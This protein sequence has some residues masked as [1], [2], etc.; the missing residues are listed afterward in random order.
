MNKKFR[1]F[2]LLGVALIAVLGVLLCKIEVSM[3]GMEASRMAVVEAVAD[4]GVYHIENTHF[5]TVDKVI[6]N[7]HI[8]SDKPIMLSWC[9]AQMCK[10][11]TLFSGRNFTNSYNF[12]IYLVNIIFGCGANILC[13]LWLFRYLCRTS[14]GDMRLKLLFAL[15]CCCGTW[16]FSFMTIFS[17]HV[18]AAL[19]VTAVMVLLDKYRRKADS[20]AAVLAGFA[21]GMLFT[22]DMVAG[23]VFLLTSA[24][25]VWFTSPV[26]K[27]VR[28][29][30]RCGASG[31]CVVAFGVCL[32][33]AAYGTVFPLYMGSGGTFSPGVDAKNHFVYFCETLFTTRGLFSYQP[34][35]LLIFPAVWFLRRKLQTN[36]K[37]MLIS[38]FSVI[39][40]YCVITNE[41]GGFS[42]G[43]RYL[44]CVIPILVYYVAKYVLERKNIRLTV[45][46]A[47]LGVAGVFCAFVGAYEPM[48][49]AFE[50]H[51][52]P[53]GHFTRNLRST[54]MSNLF[55]W[56]YETAPDSLLTRKFIGYYGKKDSFLYLRAQYVITKH[57]QTLEKLMKDSRFDLKNQSK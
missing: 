2:S 33:Y 30:L 6:R 51:R 18:P 34:L 3:A 5:R 28:D 20:R 1:K 41:F 45:C 17:N 49:V 21:S 8:Y 44:I 54:F 22:L 48:C 47:V 39:A 53:Q 29:F 55:A 35:L 7:N 52:S 23:A 15:F 40:I 13:F 19:A 56:S 32:N 27:R 37:L 38:G 43:F 36:D 16:M 14:K 25:S 50:G 11:V 24:L 46:A 57:F 4:Q 9:A 12:M 31:A 10:I 42:Y 26:E